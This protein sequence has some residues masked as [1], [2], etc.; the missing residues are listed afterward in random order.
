[1][2]QSSTPLLGAYALAHSTLPAAPTPSGVGSV[3]CGGGG[4]RVPVSTS[5]V[6]G[7]YKR[8]VNPL[9]GSGYVFRLR[10]GF[11]VL[12][13]NAQ[14][15]ATCVVNNHSR[16]YGAPEQHPGIAVRVGTYSIE[17]EPTVTTYV[18][19]TLPDPTATRLKRILEKSLGGYLQVLA[20][21]L[22]VDEL[23]SR[24]VH[25]LDPLCQVDG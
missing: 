5:I 11:Q 18:L 2:P 7:G 22:D 9:R 10:N 3:D 15:I 13:V 12:R 24:M 20:R 17:T 4:P 8:S 23:H 16:W 19:A 25:R 6:G 21:Q 14:S 1:M